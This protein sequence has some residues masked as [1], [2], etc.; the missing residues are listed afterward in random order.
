MLGKI[1]FS[2]Q[3]LWWIKNLFCSI[4]LRFFKLPGV[5]IV[6]NCPSLPSPINKVNWENFFLVKVYLSAVF[7]GFCCSRS[8]VGGNRSGFF[9][10]QQLFLHGV[11]CFPIYCTMDFKRF[12]LDFMHKKLHSMEQKL[13]FLLIAFDVWRLSVIVAFVVTGGRWSAR[14][15]WFAWWPLRH[16]NW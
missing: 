5:F 7:G 16:H 12:S 4:F 13:F 3:L 15:V 10:N 6:S 1:F 9:Y 14:L 11:F 2:P 8:S